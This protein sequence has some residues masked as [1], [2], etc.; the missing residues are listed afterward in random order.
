MA[1]SQERSIGRSISLPPPHAGRLVA[2]IGRRGPIVEVIPL[3][4]LAV[5][6][7]GSVMATTKAALMVLCSYAKCGQDGG[8]QKGNNQNEEELNN[9]RLQRIGRR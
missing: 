9:V 7:E 3:V 5:E 6:S 4:V 8:V 1:G 2:E